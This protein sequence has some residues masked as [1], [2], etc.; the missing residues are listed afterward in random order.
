MDKKAW[1]TD[2]ISGMGIERN[3]GTHRVVAGEEGGR[4]WRPP[5]ARRCPTVKRSNYLSRPALPPR[6]ASRRSVGEVLTR[7][8]AVDK[9]KP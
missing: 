9:E 4:W 7:L 5:H 3:R 6:R 1:R 2:R 8:G